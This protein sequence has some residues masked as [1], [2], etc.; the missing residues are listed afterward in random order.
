VAALGAFTLSRCLLTPTPSAGSI[1]RPKGF[2]LGFVLIESV[3]LEFQAFVEAIGQGSMASS[4][5]RYSRACKPEREGICGTGSLKALSTPGS[6]SGH[7]KTLRLL[8]GANRPATVGI[9]HSSY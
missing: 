8:E 7:R 2:Q 5:C 1:C 6:I 9:D 3:F 4:L